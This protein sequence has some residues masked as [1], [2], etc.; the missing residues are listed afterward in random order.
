MKK[1]RERTKTLYSKKK[2]FDKNLG[3]STF[4]KAEE[5]YIL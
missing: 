5:D 3:N 2:L 4:T 1:I